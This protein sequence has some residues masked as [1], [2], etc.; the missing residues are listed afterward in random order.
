MVSLNAM[1][2]LR[3]HMHVEP[4]ACKKRLL[5]CP[6]EGGEVIKLC[7]D[8]RRIYL[9]LLTVFRRSSNLAG[10]ARTHDPDAARAYVCAEEGCGRAFA[11]SQH[12]RRH[13]KLHS[14][15]TPYECT[16]EGCTAAFS[17]KNQLR[18]HICYHN[19]KKPFP[20]TEEGCDKSF[21]TSTK[22]KQHEMVHL[23]KRQYICGFAE[24]T[25]QFSKW[26]ELQKHVTNDHRV[27]CDICGKEFLRQ[28]FLKRHFRQKHM[29]HEPVVCDWEGC[30]RTLSSKKSLKMH[31]MLVHERDTRY[32][33]L[34]EGCDKGFPYKSIRDRHMESHTKVRASPKRQREP[35]PSLLE[36]IT[37]YNY[38]G[39]DSRRTL[40]C[41]FE[42][43]NLMFVR[44]YDLERHLQ[45]K[46]HH[47]DLEYL[48]SVQKKSQLDSSGDGDSTCSL[49]PGDT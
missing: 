44:A 11:T 14:A 18:R 33:C 25:A 37:G 48:E 39:A 12:L 46:A 38:A 1:E 20:C 22:L 3:E 17:K 35:E 26:T 45:S 24:C 29:E 2:A 16:W 10:H 40:P 34:V 13:E 21:D 9:R 43:C 15:P 27:T 7:S 36:M 8:F 28:T 49:T 32:K 5:V 4:S 41:P 19:G 30:S 6:F 47:H 31:I 23:D 42:G